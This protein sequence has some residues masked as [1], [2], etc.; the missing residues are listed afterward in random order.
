KLAEF[1]GPEQAHIAAQTPA[2]APPVP[3]SWSE[4]VVS[5]SVV[6]ASTSKAPR[7]DTFDVSPFE[8]E[9]GLKSA[10]GALAGDFYDKM[11]MGG[12]EKGDVER[13]TGVLD[14]GNGGERDPRDVAFAEGPNGRMGKATVF[15]KAYRG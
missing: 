7:K 2:P 5:V 14:G 15:G 1:V 4:S 13:L 9:A 6:A 8:I 11:M 12:V 3:V 10:A